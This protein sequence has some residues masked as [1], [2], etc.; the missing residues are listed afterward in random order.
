MDYRTKAYQAFDMF[1][2]QWPLITAGTM[3][4]FNSCTISWGSLGNLWGD[5]GKSRATVTVYVHPTRYTCEFLRRSEQFTVS[6]LSP[7]YK[8]MLGYMGTHSGRDGDKAA[9]S[10]L[11]PIALNDTVGYEE[12]ALTFVCRKLYQHQFAREDMAADIQA[13]YAA[14]PEHFSDGHGGWQPHIVF[15]GEILDVVEQ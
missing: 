9:A 10:G 2:S 11:T 7:A 6:F 8:K 5:P 15:V 4:H 14:H 3:E 12:A 1:D 13:H